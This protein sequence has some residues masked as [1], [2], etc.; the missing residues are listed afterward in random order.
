MRDI[1]QFVS[2]PLHIFNPGLVH[3]EDRVLAAEA[4]A[5]IVAQVVTHRAGIPHRPGQQM[6]HA[7][8]RRVT[9]MPGNGP[10][11]LPWQL[12][13]QAQQQLLRPTTRLNPTETAS[14]PPRQLIEHRPPSGRVYAGARGRQTIL[15]SP[16]NRP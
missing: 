11:V 13:Y 3:D 6:L 14:D 2:M 4:I 5:D 8:R 10:A 12:R 16:H 15:R 1:P 7:I 9:N